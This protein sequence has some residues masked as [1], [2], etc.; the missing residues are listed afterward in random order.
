MHHLISSLE[1]K[2]MLKVGFYPRWVHLEEISG[3][4]RQAHFVFS[5]IVPLV[6]FGFLQG[7]LELQGWEGPPARSKISKKSG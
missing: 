2:Q 6:G 5:F 7:S 1:L 4:E 3:R